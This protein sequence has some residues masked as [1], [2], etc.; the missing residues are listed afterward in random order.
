MSADYSVKMKCDNCEKEM[1]MSFV[2]RKEVPRKVECPNC[3]VV[4]MKKA[5][6]VDDSTAKWMDV[7][8]NGRSA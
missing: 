3:G 6:Q 1:N 4:A 5:L 2:Y 8:F 7:F